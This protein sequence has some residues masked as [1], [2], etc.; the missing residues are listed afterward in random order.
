MKVIS[1][2]ENEG[3]VIGGDINITVLEIRTD[4]VRL[5][6]SCPRLVPSYWEQTLFVQVQE[7]PSELELSGARY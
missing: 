1:R 4:R 3:L 2:R 5:A 7:E 6:I